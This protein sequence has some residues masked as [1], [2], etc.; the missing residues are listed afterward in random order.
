MTT[1]IT[2]RHSYM[3]G[4]KPGPAEALDRLAYFMLCGFLF[5]LP[6]EEAPQLGGFAIGRWLASAALGIAITRLLVSGRSRKPSGVH[7][8]L[9][10]LILL[11]GLS[12]FWTVDPDA[13]MVR[14]GTY[15]QLLAAVWLMWELAPAEIRVL[16]LMRSY[17]FGIFFAALLTIRN[18]A[19][20]TTAAQ[21]SAAQGIDKWE[22]GRY[23][24]SGVNENDL[25][26]ML[27]MCIPIIIYFAIRSR[28]VWMKLFFWLQLA[29]CV[30]AI[31]LTA[32]RGAAVSAAIA[33]LMLP[34]SLARLGPS[35]KIA[36]TLACVTVIFG[37]VVFA[38]ADVWT[39]LAQFQT[40]L[41]QGT[42]TN[43]TY[44][45][46]AGLTAL[47]DHA[48]IG[49]GA[50]AYGA[51]IL[52]AVGLPYPAHN[53]FLSI[54]VELGAVG[55]L[56]FTGLLAGLYYTASRMQYLERCLWFTVLLTWTTGVMALTWEYHKPTWVMFG[57]LLAHAYSRRL[58]IVL[59]PVPLRSKMKYTA[60]AAPRNV[61]LDQATEARPVPV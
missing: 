59:S 16:G 29:A 27:A 38:P 49:V 9:L 57:L 56:L 47:R 1:R 53:T 20:G 43:R 7:F 32:S 52:P 46:A 34:L 45:W 42:L 54:L 60:S 36:V 50:G 48:F 61:V 31:L 33:L 3:F 21:L 41:T 4:S 13:T 44:I 19:S 15:A 51:T 26:L 35:Q 22:E 10:G 17:A 11:S 58:K 5:V 28:G 30:A 18:Y 6:W 23:S 40:E 55:A 25:G 8:L 12:L 37:G 24:I 14:V 39:R 2:I